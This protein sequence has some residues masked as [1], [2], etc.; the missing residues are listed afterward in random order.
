MALGIVT[1]KMLIHGN[2]HGFREAWATKQVLSLP[3][4]HKKIPY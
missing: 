3:V 2:F 4:I 1:L